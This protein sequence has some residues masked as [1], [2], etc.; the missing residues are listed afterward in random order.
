MA[1]HTIPPI[2]MTFWQTGNNQNSDIVWNG[3]WFVWESLKRSYMSKSI[4][5]QR[6]ERLHQQYSTFEAYDDGFSLI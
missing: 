5:F 3:S 2:I 6:R 1:S 4:N